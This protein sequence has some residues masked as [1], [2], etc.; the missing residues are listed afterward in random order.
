V[1]AAR[2]TTLQREKVPGVEQMKGMDIYLRDDQGGS[3]ASLSD[4][5]AQGDGTVPAVASAM[6]VDQAVAPGNLLVRDSGYSH[7]Q[8]YKVGGNSEGA[9]AALQ[10]I[11]RVLNA[12]MKT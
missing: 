4:P 9:M 11:V 10:A 1:D 8:S 2:H 12:E 7:D 3:H 5:D 6:A